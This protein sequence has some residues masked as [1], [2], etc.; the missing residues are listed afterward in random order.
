MSSTKT[1]KT[2]ATVQLVISVSV[3]IEDFEKFKT[4][5]GLNPTKKNLAEFAKENW[6]EPKAGATVWETAVDRVEFNETD[7]RITKRGIGSY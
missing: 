6:Q 1:V 4:D 3:P 5:T 2:S 7:I